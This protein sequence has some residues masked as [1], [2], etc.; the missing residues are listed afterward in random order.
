MSDERLPCEVWVKKI[1]DLPEN[2]GKKSVKIELFLAKQWV[3]KS[4]K[5]SKCKIKP[6]IYRSACLDAMYRLR[7]D[8]KWLQAEGYHLWFLTYQEAIEIFTQI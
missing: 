8:G 4:R 1:K 2:Q 7:I 6:N 3:H 5:G